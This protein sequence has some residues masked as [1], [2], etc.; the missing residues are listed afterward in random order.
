MATDD[1]EYDEFEDDSEKDFDYD[2]DEDE[3]DEWYQISQSSSR[4]LQPRVLNLKK[5]YLH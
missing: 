3:D 2:Y 1:Y 5:I 4:L